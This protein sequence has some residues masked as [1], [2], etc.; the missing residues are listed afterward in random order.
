[1]PFFRAIYKKQLLAQT[2]NRGTYVSQ[3]DEFFNKSEVNAKWNRT[4]YATPTLTGRIEKR[5][6]KP[7]SAY[8]VSLTEKTQF[9]QTG[10]YFQTERQY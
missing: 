5:Q 9:P 7:V 6:Q 1:M 3:P 10:L 2:K 4:V 8:S